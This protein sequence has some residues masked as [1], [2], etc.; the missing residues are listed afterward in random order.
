M[1]SL[2]VNDKKEP[3]DLEPQVDM[4]VDCYFIDSNDTEQ[5][6]T[7]GKY[8]FDGVV[9]KEE[10]GYIESSQVD[11]DAQNETIENKY[12]KLEQVPIKSS[13]SR[14]K[15]KISSRTEFDHQK[16]SWVCAT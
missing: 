4:S 7:D 12:E 2:D 13:S 1:G 9:V 11:F 14:R 8:N 6:F 15:Q 10:L 3:V 5:N 16:I